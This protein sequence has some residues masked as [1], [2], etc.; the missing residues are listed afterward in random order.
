MHA[1]LAKLLEETGDDGA[2][3]RHYRK[4]LQYRPDFQFPRI[5]LAYLLVSLARYDEALLH[6]EEAVRI[7]PKQYR[8]HNALGLIKTNQG[9]PE[10][11]VEHYREALRLWPDYSVAR[12]NLQQ[13]QMVNSQKAVDDDRS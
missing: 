12:E 4:A 10:Q 11:A 2:A 7:N 6:A 1:A 13:L 8:A 3:L 5:E 9:K